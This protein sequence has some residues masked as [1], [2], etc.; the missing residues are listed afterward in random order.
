[1]KRHLAS[2][3]VF[4]LILSGCGSV[5]AGL[6]TRPAGSSP[7]EGDRAEL[8]AAGEALWNDTNLG[9]AGV[10]CGSCHVGGGQFKDTF[11]EPY[12][13]RVAMADKMS[14]LPSID[15]E[16][17]VQFCM[18]VPMKSEPLAW[19]SRE[20]AALAAYIDDVEQPNYANK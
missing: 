10:S 15:A 14:G 16:Q 13:H 20:L 2:G 9:A 8:V 7:F 11:K 19:D 12:P 3:A 18:I 17:M 4:A 1:M 6:V 5:D